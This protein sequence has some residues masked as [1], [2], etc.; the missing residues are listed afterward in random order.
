MLPGLILL[1][2]AAYSFG[3]V[4]WHVAQ[5]YGDP[6]QYGNSGLT[7]AIQNAYERAPHTFLVTGITFVLALQLISLG[8]DRGAG[9]ALLRG[10][11]PPRHRR[12][13]A[14]PRRADRRRP[15][16]DDDEESGGSVPAGGPGRATGRR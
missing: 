7:G 15:D 3:W 13:A 4:I 12:S 6:S 11:V 5:V 1:A 14:A 10:A 8:V 2:V 16:L 9:Q